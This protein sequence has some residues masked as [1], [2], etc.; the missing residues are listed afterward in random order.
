MDGKQTSASV[1][2]AEDAFPYGGLSPLI[3]VGKQPVTAAVDWEKSVWQLMQ[4]GYVTHSL[5][6]F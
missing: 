2:S 1:A 3:I 6:H 5:L 4:T